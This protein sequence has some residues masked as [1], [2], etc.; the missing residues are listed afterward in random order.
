MKNFKMKISVMRYILSVALLFVAIAG[1]SEKV[2]KPESWGDIRFV[3]YPT[4][5]A[6]FYGSG[7]DLSKD[8]NIC[9]GD[10]DG[11][12]EVHMVQKILPIENCPGEYVVIRVYR[13]KDGNF[14]KKSVRRLS[15]GPVPI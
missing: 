2:K 10:T 4:T 7:I 11:G 14:L 1:H 3:R 12:V 5:K 15:D 13:D 8:W 6:I 9:T